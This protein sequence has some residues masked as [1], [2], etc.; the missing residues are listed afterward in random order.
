MFRMRRALA[1]AT[2]ISGVAGSGAADAADLWRGGSGDSI[3]VRAP[4]VYIYDSEPG[5]YVRAYWTQPWENRRYFPF[6]GKKP[7]IG[8]VEKVADA[9]PGPGEYYYREWS[10]TTFP[11]VER[12]TVVVR[13]PTQAAPQYTVPLR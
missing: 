3:G 4:R 8:R 7:K 9:R 2:I 10:T 11:A 6:T 13:E 5:V 1:I 12:Q